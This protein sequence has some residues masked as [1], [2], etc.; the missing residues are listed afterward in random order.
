MFRIEKN[1]PCLIGSIPRWSTSYSI[2]KYSL[3]RLYTVISMSKRFFVSQGYFK[4]NIHV[5]H[6]MS[7]IIWRHD[8]QITR[9]KF[10]YLE[11][12][13]KFIWRSYIQNQGFCSKFFQTDPSCNISRRRVLFEIEPRWV[14]TSVV[15]AEFETERFDLFI[16]NPCYF[17]EKF[18][19]F[20]FKWIQWHVANQPNC[21]CK[22]HSHTLMWNL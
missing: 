12:C 10:E 16:L 18:R 15:L 13:K 11:N 9:L 14:K 21:T 4:R 7:H 8:D 22:I 6:A 17:D 3:T 1:E 19:F 2:I 5:W 20:C